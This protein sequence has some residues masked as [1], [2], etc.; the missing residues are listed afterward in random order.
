[1]QLY[2][3]DVCLI[4]G[5]DRDAHW[6]RIPEA[7]TFSSHVFFSVPFIKGRNI[8]QRQREFHRA[9]WGVCYIVSPSRFYLWV[10]LDETLL[11]FS[12][13]RN[14]IEGVLWTDL[15]AVRFAALMDVKMSMLLLHMTSQPTTSKKRLLSPAFLETHERVWGTFLFLHPPSSFNDSLSTESA[16]RRWLDSECLW[17]MN[18]VSNVCDLF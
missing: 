5:C 13:R 11:R 1:M 12:K 9:S 8:V 10:Y 16:V 17:T 7:P 14:H 3:L 15:R 2:D 18:L 6:Q 4:P